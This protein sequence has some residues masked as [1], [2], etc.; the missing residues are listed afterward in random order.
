[1]SFG[2]ELLK[3]DEAGARLGRVTTAHGAFTTPVFMPVGTKATVKTMT[4]EELEDT[5]V[6]IILANTYHLYLRPGHNVIKDLGGL[7]SF[8]NW[9]G[10]IL[11]DSGGFQV[12]SLSNLR[13]IDERGVT[14]NSHLDGA[15]YTLTPENTVEVQEALGSDIIMPL[16]ECAPS[17][18]DREYTVRSMNLT[19]RWALRSKAAKREEGPALFGIVQGGMFA[20]LRRESAATLVEA[21]FDGY[22]IGGLS[23]GEEKDVMREMTYAAVEHLPEESP[24]YLMGV[25][26]P[27]DLVLGVE[28]GIDMFDCVM[29]T[30]NARNGTLFTSG[31]KLVI[32]N[33]R[34]ER[35]PEPVDPE[36]A[37]YTCS[38]YSRA[39]LRHLFMAGEILAMRLNTL[40]N[41]YYYTALMKDM[42]RAV[43]EDAFGDF[44]KSFFGRL[45]ALA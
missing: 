15:R 45:A 33:S 2:F 5:G 13:K 1:M 6:D 22:A 44:K 37:C 4:P 7:H 18:A 14:F 19:H 32:K 38:N 29:P 12:F 25:G 21:G 10:P 20:D 8:M 27:E 24:R 36:C 42:Q 40:H 28:A 31:G 16:D 23:V 39:Y 35:D 17:G 41:L 34:F 9:Q 11:T 30:R 43:R 26:T 3:K